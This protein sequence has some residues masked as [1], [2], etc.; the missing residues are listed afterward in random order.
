MTGVVRAR[1]QLVDEQPAVAG[2]EELDAEDAHHVQLLQERVGQPHGLPRHALLHAGGRDGHVEDVALM[3]VLDRPPVGDGAIDA[4][5]GHD[6]DLAL[7]IHEG[8]EDRRLAARTPPRL[9]D[10]GG[11][12]DAGLPL[13]VVAEPGRLQHGGIAQPLEAEAEVV[14]AIRRARRA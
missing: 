12:V 6:G 4:A 10:V 9:L 7:E 2:E 8:L 3:P 5:R 11:G 1:G 13:A 14:R